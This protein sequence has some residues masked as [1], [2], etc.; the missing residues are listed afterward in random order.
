MAGDM[1]ALVFRGPSRITLEPRPVPAIGSPNDVLVRVTHSGICGTD[2]NIWRGRFPARPGTVLG[3][4]ATGLVEKCGDAVRDLSVGQKVVIDPTLSCG[5][6]T[7]CRKGQFN[8]CDHK[9][10]AE[11]GVDRDGSHAQF[12][13]L[14]QRFV[15]RLPDHIEA[16]KAVLIEPTAC[17]LNNVQA[18]QLSFA[19]KVLIVGGGPIGLL[20]AL[21]A[22][23]VAASCALVESS[24]YRL[25]LASNLGV[26]TIQP[27]EAQR[28][29]A[30]AARRLLGGLPSVVVDTTGSFAEEGFALLDKGGRLVLMGFDA[31][32]RICLPQQ[33]IV[34]RALKIIGAGDYNLMFP[35]AI[36][37]VQRAPV[38][39]IVTHTLTL[40]E[41]LRAMD[42]LTGADGRGAAAADKVVLMPSQGPHPLSATR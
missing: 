21:C 35:A 19:D 25:T 22:K 32:R 38:E 15:Y 6:C 28:G 8:L 16:K 18:S 34:S 3:H 11:V 41:F 37:F 20:W 7:Y 36:D 24:A 12:V 5:H 4:E 13:V 39:R 14:P 40:E 10:G 2:L 27:V 17:V 29:M 42:L 33:H 30:D 31:Q 9:E 23:D 26:A 1:Q